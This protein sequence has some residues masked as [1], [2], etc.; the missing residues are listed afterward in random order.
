MNE[1]EDFKEVYAYA[2]LSFLWLKEW[3]KFSAALW[4]SERRVVEDSSSR[5]GR[6][7]VV[8]L[9]TSL[10]MHDSSLSGQSYI[11][12]ERME[13]FLCSFGDVCAWATTIAEQGA[14]GRKSLVFLATSEGRLSALEALFPFS[15][16]PLCSQYSGI[17]SS[18]IP[19]S[20]CSYITTGDTT[21]QSSHKWERDAWVG[22][23]RWLLSIS[24]MLCMSNG[25]NPRSDTSWAST[26]L[27]T[28]IVSDGKWNVYE[29]L[30]SFCPPPFILHIST[31]SVNTWKKCIYFTLGYYL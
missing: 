9:P 29:L 17:E 26:C 11:S 10:L 14:G 2:A 6:A 21:Y 4:A 5:M 20:S 15:P 1:G 18:L 19:F 31:G 30:I 23:R 7:T 27:I 12:G 16:S 24:Q 8:V 28:F 3:A 25:S 22:G 13:H